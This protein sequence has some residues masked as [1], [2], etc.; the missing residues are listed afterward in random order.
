[1]KNIRTIYP[2]FFGDVTE[3]ISIDAAIKLQV[4]K[5]ESKGHLYASRGMVI[6]D[7][8]ACPCT[9]F[10]DDPIGKTTV[11]YTNDKYT[12]KDATTIGDAQFEYFNKYGKFPVDKSDLDEFL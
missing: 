3:V 11:P 4:S 10:T 1:M 5:A 12:I 8:L 9:S 2:D 7:I 6:R